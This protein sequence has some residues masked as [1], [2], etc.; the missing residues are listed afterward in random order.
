MGKLIVI[1]GLDGAGKTTQINLI[2]KY[3]NEKKLSF[4]FFHFPMYGHNEFSEVISKFLRGEFGG[5]DEV[6]PL[7]IATQYAMDRYMFLPELKNALSKNDIVLLDRYVYS[8][9][10]FQ[11]AKVKNNSHIIRNWI[12]NFEFEFLKLPRPDLN[13]FI[14]IPLDVI[15]ERLGN[16]REGDDRNYL[17]GKKDIHE[18]S[19]D[20]QKRVRDE[21]LNIFGNF[22][23]INGEILFENNTREI[24]SPEDLFKSY[25]SHIENIL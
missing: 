11:C 8:N 12:E 21:Y 9:V 5:V 22:F 10:A 19:M 23:K 16:K 3:L 7:F 18:S 25:L 13:I 17:Q 6:N 24:L 15:E 1:E 14:D 4:E 2:K 20:F